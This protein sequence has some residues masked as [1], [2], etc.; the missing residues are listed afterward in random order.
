MLKKN[1]FSKFKMAKKKPV[2]NKTYNKLLKNS[3]QDSKKQREVANELGYKRDDK[4]S[5]VQTQ[6]L[7]KEGEKPLIIHRGSKNVQDFIDDGLIGLGLGKYTHRVKQTKRLTKK[8]IEKTGERPTQIGH[9]LGGYL[10]EQNAKDGDEVYTYNKHAVGFTGTKKN[11]NQTD[12]RDFGDLASLPQA[13]SSKTNVLTMKA[14]YGKG[15]GKNNVI[16][17]LYAHEIKDYE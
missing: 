3:Y 11:S 7:Q 14:R 5:S 15:Y 16:N 12:V 1:H 9:S 17:P 13:F 10:A 2:V 4:L 8:V 6:V